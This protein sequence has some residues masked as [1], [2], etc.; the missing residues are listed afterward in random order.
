MPRLELIL[1][2]STS[3]GGYNAEAEMR[4]ARGSPAIALSHE[5]IQVIVRMGWNL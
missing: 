5:P 1:L 3:A 4:Q 2:P